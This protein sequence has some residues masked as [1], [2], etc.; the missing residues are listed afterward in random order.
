MSMPGIQILLCTNGTETSRS[1]LSYGVWMAQVL[2]TSVVLLG[3]LEHQEDRSGLEKLLAETGV[4]LD[5]NNVSYQTLIREGR[6]SI[7]IPNHAKMGNFLTIVGPLGRPTW[8][9]W[10]RGRTFRRLLAGM[11]SP[12]IYVPE[13]R[14]SLRHILV[15]M[16]GLGYAFSMEQVILQLAQSTGARLT[17]L[18]VV[19]PVTFDYPVAKEVQHHW[20]HLLETDTPQGRNLQKAVRE[21]EGAGLQVDVKVRHGNV[22]GEILDEV[23]GKDYDLIGLGSPYSGHSLRHL[24]I[25]NV[26]AEVA[27]A[28]DRPVLTVRSGFEIVV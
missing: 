26:T 21:A 2:D 17:L 12:L 1:A 5:Q 6:A 15:C 9:R 11:A 24:F 10:L 20:K 8:R 27:E 19:E 13:E 28:I 3:I 22:V 23:R 18:N 25:P 7:Q 14:L 4:R 16:G